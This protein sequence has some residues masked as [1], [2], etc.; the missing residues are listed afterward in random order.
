MQD[1]QNIKQTDQTKIPLNRVLG[2]A[3]GILL[4]AGMMIGSGVFKK[5]I[6]M[7]QTGLSQNWIIGAWIVAGIITMF[8]AFTI[9]GLATLTEESGGVYEYLRLSFGNFL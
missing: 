7:A 1:E 3:T 6:P 9:S 4:V 8:G 2:L 5:I